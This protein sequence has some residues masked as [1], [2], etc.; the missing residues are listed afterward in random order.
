MC[1]AVNQSRLTDW[2]VR[3]ANGSCGPSAERRAWWWILRGPSP[4]PCWLYYRCSSWLF[5]AKTS[6]RPPG[7]VPVLLTGCPQVTAPIWTKICTGCCV[8]T[9]YPA[10]LLAKPQTALLKEIWSLLQLGSCFW[11][12][13]LF[14]WLLM[15]L[16]SSSWLQ[17]SG[18]TGTS[19]QLS[20]RAK[21]VRQS[22]L[23][24]SKLIYFEVKLKVNTL[25][26]LVIISHCAGKLCE[27]SITAAQ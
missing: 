26:M 1:V 22:N 11:S 2:E 3:L 13:G 27:C 4:R 18:N 20:L 6:V 8:C 15:T 16:D 19:L 12:S 25:E 9:K 24:L 17:R 10:F 23:F 21:L 14:V 5:T 7:N